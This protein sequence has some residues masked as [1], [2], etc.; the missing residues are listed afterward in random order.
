[1]CSDDS[2]HISSSTSLEG[3]FCDLKINEFNFSCLAVIKD[4][5]RLDIPMTDVPIVDIFNCP[6]NLSD[7]TF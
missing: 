5:F 1:M 2:E 4:V 7:N 3:L 6:N